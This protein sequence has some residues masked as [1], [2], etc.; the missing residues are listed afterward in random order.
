MEIEICNIINVFILIII[1]N[2]ETFFVSND[3][4]LFIYIFIVIQ[5]D[6]HLA[7]LV[8]DYQSINNIDLKKQLSALWAI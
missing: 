5:N 7:N 2:M 6:L 4:V 8:R 3:N 1:L